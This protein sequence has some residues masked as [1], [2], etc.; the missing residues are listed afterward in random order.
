MR[1]EGDTLHAKTGV[2]FFSEE[3][4]GVKP[5]TVRMVSEKEWDEIRTAWAQG[6]I[7]HICISATYSGNS[8]RRR[9]TRI[10]KLGELV[11][12]VQIAIGWDQEPGAGR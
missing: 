12:F 10:W 6:G 4:R 7:T 3:Q 9:I 11:G 2:G 5:F 8:F 1:I